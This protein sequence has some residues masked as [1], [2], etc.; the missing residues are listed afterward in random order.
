MQTISQAFTCRPIG[1]RSS[2]KSQVCFQKS[3]KGPTRLL[4]LL[5]AQTTYLSQAIKSG[6]Q[7]V[8]QL[9]ELLWRTLRGQRS[10]SLN[11]SKKNAVVGDKVDV[12]S[13]VLVVVAEYSFQL[14]REAI[15]F[16]C[17]VL[18]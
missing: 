14:V 12:S 16:C 13:V 17:F 11:V 2:E 6:K 18:H 7:I 15:L 10:E 1:K 3:S 5:V 4:P 8:E 9:D